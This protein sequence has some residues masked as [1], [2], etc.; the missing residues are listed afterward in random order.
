[1]TRPHPPGDNSSN[2]EVSLALLLASRPEDVYSDDDDRLF[3]AVGRLL[4]RDS[5]VRRSSASIP[6]SPSEES[7][8]GS[9]LELSLGDGVAE[10][11]K[12]G[13]G[14]VDIAATVHVRVQIEQVGIEHLFTPG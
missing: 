10:K 1:M 13:V 4:D 2:H 14:G 8:I 5:R 3:E 12:S 7:S 9:R 6:S 11:H